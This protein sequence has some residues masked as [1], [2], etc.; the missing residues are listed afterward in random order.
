M[1]QDQAV[2]LQMGTLGK[3]TGSGKSVSGWTTIGSGTLKHPLKKGKVSNIEMWHVDQTIQVWEDGVLIAKG[4]YDW[5]PA[6]RVKNTIGLST[7]DVIAEWTAHQRNVLAE[8]S[9]YPNP[10]IRWEVS[11]PV[12]MHRVGLR[13]DIH[14]QASMRTG[15]LAGR[16]TH[17][18]T[19]MSLNRDQFF[20]CGD[21]SPQSLDARLWGDPDPWVAKVIDGT[22]GV[23]PRDLMIGKAFFVYFPSLFTGES[24][25]LPVPDFGRMRW[26]F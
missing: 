20:V 11:S 16:A 9:R 24:S 26:I 17:P 13:R 15:N 6:E 5:S 14:Y 21:N 12:R 18:L 4:E 23:V 8:Q 2:T 25:G 7:K 1:I 22:H 3:D 10:E 19:T